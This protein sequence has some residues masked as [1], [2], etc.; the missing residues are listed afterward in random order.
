VPYV[1]TF[2]SGF[3]LILVLTRARGGL[4]GLFFLPRDP[5]VE[6]LVWQEQESGGSIDGGRA[7]RKASHEPMRK[8]STAPGR[9]PRPARS[10]R[11]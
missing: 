6:G 8:Q 9:T 2:G 5:V 4:A 11:R 10:A 7:P 3:A 1:V